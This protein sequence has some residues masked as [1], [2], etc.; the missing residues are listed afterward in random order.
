MKPKDMSKKTCKKYKK[1]LKIA[2]IGQ[3]GDGKSCFAT[4]LFKGIKAFIPEH[5]TDLF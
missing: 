4:S 3:I 5:E 1:K 2:V